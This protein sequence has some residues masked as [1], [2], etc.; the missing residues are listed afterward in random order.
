[1]NPQPTQPQHADL[2]ALHSQIA[3]CKA[4][5]LFAL[6][7]A[8]EK[9][10]ARLMRERGIAVLRVYSPAQADKTPP[11]PV[12][13]AMAGV[14]VMEQLAEVGRIIAAAQVNVEKLKALTGSNP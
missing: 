3:E 6:A 8:L 7:D 10:P 14:P 9:T 1:M 12:S 5:Q 11:E 2:Y 4:E 13:V